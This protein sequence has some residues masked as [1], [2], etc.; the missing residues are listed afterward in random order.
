MPHFNEV[1]ELLEESLDETNIEQ[2]DIRSI[3]T[4]IAGLMDKIAVNE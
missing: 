4:L 3:I 2:E 1:V